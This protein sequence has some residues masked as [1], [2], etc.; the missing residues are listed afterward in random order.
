MTNELNPAFFNIFSSTKADARRRLNIP[1]CATV[2]LIFGGGSG[3]API[4][5]AI[6]NDL[7][8]LT[9]AYYI[10][11]V[12]GKGNTVQTDVKNYQQFEFATDMGSL[13]A[14]ADVVIARAGAGTVF[15]I[16]ALKKPSLLI[17]LEGQT[18]GDQVQNAQ[19]FQSKGLCRVLRQNQL[20]KLSAEIEK[21]VLDKTLVSTLE[22][23]Q[24]T[25]GNSTIL[26]A[27]F[28]CEKKIDGKGEP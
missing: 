19:Y 11:H 3:S 13:Y 23:A 6:F 5:K 14:A 20:S 9:Q 27:L 7:P 2:L 26:A 28:A 18:R 25:S 16:L 15:E 10:L 8:H 4:N 24:F 1:F 17:P 12:V 21:T 22:N